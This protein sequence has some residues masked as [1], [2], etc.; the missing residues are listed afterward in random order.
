[1]AVE[2]A[3]TA[4]WCVAVVV[5]DGTAAVDDDDVVPGRGTKIGGVV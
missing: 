3:A 4:A 5:V 1:V 2:L